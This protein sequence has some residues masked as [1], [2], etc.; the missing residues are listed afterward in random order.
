MAST[1]RPCSTPWRARPAASRRSPWSRATRPTG[2]LA[3]LADRGVVGVRFNLVNFDRACAR[4][5][6]SARLLDRLKARGSGSPRSMR[7]TSNGR[8]CSRCFGTAASESSSIISASA[9]S[10]RASLHPASRPCSSLGGGGNAA[11]KL[12][13]PFRIAAAGRSA[14]RASTRMSKPARRPSASS[15]ASGARTGPSSALDH[16]IRYARCR[17]RSIAGCPTR[18]TASGCCGAIRP[19]CS[20]SV[21]D[22][23]DAV[24]GSARRCEGARLRVGLAGAGM[25]SHHHLVAW[26]RE[27]AR[28]GR[29]DLRSA[30]RAQARRRAGGIRYRRGL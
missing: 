15:A 11:V 26:S 2:T 19:A 22:R 1:I 7:R 30:I 9:I 21:S 16:D 29:R 6:G 27:R 3:A 10:A 20:A 4:P 5:S 13:A 17:R 14:M 12:S 25:I 23:H 24:L 8:R 18:P 28:R